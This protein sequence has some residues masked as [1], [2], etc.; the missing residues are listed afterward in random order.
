[1]LPT[2]LIVFR[3]VLEAALVVGIVLAASQGV[4][5]RGAWVGAGIVGGICGAALVAGFAEQIASALAGVGQELFNAAVLFIAVA[6]L[7]WQ[8]VWMGRHGRELA[9]EAGDVGKLV[10]S[11]ARPLYALGV[12]VGLAVLR[13]GSEL[14]L[15]LY[16]IVAAN[17]TDAISFGAGFALGVAAGAGVG[18][19]LYFGLLR[20]PL[21]HLFTVT[22]W[23]ILLLA[24][25]MA[26]Q[27]A[28]FLVQADVLPPLGDGVWDT[29]WL[30]TE[31][32]IPGQV[33]HALVGYVA[34]PTGIQIVFYAATLL[35]IGGLMRWV[36]GADDRQRQRRV[37]VAPRPAE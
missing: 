8:N 19:L 17:G 32:S 28:A 2:A 37:K 1:M 16:S 29:S 20:I 35:V 30:L 5:R 12:V 26:A 31:H 27:G 36:S 21:K 3:E 34:K 10:R 11:G 22:S 14:V 15:F 6:M 33:L 25:G 7:G 13:E 9:V 23:L 24:A 18:A 4:P